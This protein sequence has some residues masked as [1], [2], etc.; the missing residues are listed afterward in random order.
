[1]IR[2]IR[3]ESMYVPACEIKR[4]RGPIVCPLSIKAHGPIVV[5]EWVSTCSTVLMFVIT[6]FIL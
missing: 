6:G 3:E 4:E 5:S 2:N 1:M